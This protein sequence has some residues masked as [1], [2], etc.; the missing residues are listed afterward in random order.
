M[1]K[2][3]HFNRS[4]KITAIALI[5]AMLS[6]LLVFGG[7]TSDK[8]E[9]PSTT[10]EVT[11]PEAT[12]EVTTPEA[13]PEVTTPEA[14]PEV[15]TPEATP[16]VTT[17]EATPE[18][19]TP[20]ATPE[21]TTPEATPEV[22]TPETTPAVTEPVSP[23][24]LK[25]VETFVS[26]EVMETITE[27]F[28]SKNSLFSCYVTDPAPFAIRNTMA[29]S[30]C[31]LLSITIPVYKTLGADENGDF[32]FTISV[33]KNTN[34]GISRA[35]SRK[36]TV[37]INGAEYGI[38]ANDASVFKMITV[39]LSSYDIVLAE[40][41][42]VAFFGA[43]DTLYPGYLLQDAENKNE[44]AVF[45][46]NNAPEALGFYTYAGRG[47]SL[48][49]SHNS[50]VYNFELERTFDTI[51]EKQ[52]YENADAE[53]EKMLE[54]LR[55]KYSG[56]K[57]S[58][59]GDSIST[60]R[61]ISNNVNYNKTIG[62]NAVYYPD[63]NPNFVTHNALYWGRL[64]NDLEMELC[65]DNAWSGSYVYG[66]S[67]AS[68]N[69]SMPR[70]AT[71]LSHRRYGDPDLIIVYM[72]IN[73]LHHAAEVPFGNLYNKISKVTD[74]AER[75]AIVAQ[76]FEALKA[77]SDANP[78]YVAGTSYAEWAEAYALGLYAMKEKYQNADIYCMTLIKNN[79][80]RCT[81]A[82]IEGFNA[83][84]RAI[85]DYLEIGLIDQ[86]RDGYI[87]PENCH[88]YS[89]DKTALHPSPYGHLLMEKLIVETLY[90][91]LEK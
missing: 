17:P 76:W 62:S 48:N 51:A 38:E 53:F 61:R 20:E 33:I 58:I 18:V 80:S 5:A 7:C 88:A 4:R 16:E 26:P 50:L 42:T 14:T 67:G 57:I 41:E 21:V 86:E 29:I 59:L 19:T 36:Y 89:G 84:I 87:T 39:D 54:A 85:A 77:T 24:D 46:K 90:K 45:W 83:C 23:E 69:D 25:L 55:V 12:P 63:N 56:K 44:A 35:P 47:F 2:T 65:V 78:G 64:M 27:L 13:T 43:A 91:N 28:E 60:F 70:R 72:G 11:T 34:T 32:T 81:D 79:D 66:Q 71:E 22:T 68:F 75:R 52:A 49:Q 30:D 3:A 40:D 1:K 37:K 9:T 73:D 31:R 74:E 8:P 82:R 6:V 15:T 10:P